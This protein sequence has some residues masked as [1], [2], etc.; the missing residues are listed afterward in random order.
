M[1]LFALCLRAISMTPVV[2]KSTL[3]RLLFRFYDVT[4]GSV[5]IDGQDV[6]SVTMRSLRSSIGE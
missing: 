1:R 5:S 2:G 6:R 3:A 4:G